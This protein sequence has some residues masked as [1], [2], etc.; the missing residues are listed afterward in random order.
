MDATNSWQIRYTSRL[1]ERK[2]KLSSKRINCTPDVAV[3]LVACGRASEEE[4]C[5]EKWYSCRAVLRRCSDLARLC[6]QTLRLYSE[7]TAVFESAVA[8]AVADDDDDDESFNDIKLAS[9]S[10]YSIW[11]TRK[12]L[13]SE[14]SSSVWY[15]LCCWQRSASCRERVDFPDP[16]SPHKSVTMEVFGGLINRW[17]FI[18]SWLVLT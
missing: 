16:G 10:S 9:I 17:S 2:W 1:M 13:F 8:V 5:R 6:F 12:I 11:T 15:S 18:F 7:V 3:A 4:I 14:S